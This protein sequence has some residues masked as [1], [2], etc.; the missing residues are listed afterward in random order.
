MDNVVRTERL[1]WSELP[2]RLRLAL[3][4]AVLG[5]GCTVLG[6]IL[7]LVQP[8]PAPG[9]S[10]LPLLIA[11]AVLPA[12]LAVG[13]IVAGRP[14]FAAGVL[15][16]FALLAP[17]RAVADL[18]LAWDALLA[19]RPE[20]LVPTSL[21]PMS[22]AAGL[23]ILL[24]GHV[25][26][27]LA[28]LLAVGAGAQPG[29]AYAEELEVPAGTS[30]RGG[31]R[32]LIGWA[33]VCGTVA[34]GGLL[35][36]AFYSHD[37]FQLTPEVVVSPSLVLAGGL[38][39]IAAVVLGCVVFTASAVPPALARGGL[40]GLF[41]GV[42]A[43]TMPAIVAG[44]AVPRLDPAP[45]PYIALGA[46]GLLVLIVYLRSEGRVREADHSRTELLLEANRLHL[47]AGALGIVAG[48]AALAGGLGTQLVVEAGLEQPESFANRQLVPAG[49][50]VGLLGAALLVGRWSA[51]V[52]P[53][54]T[55]SLAAVLVVGAG[56]LDA[57]LTG[58]GISP[59]VHVG[60]GVWAT[61][62]AMALAVVA[63][64]CAGVA[65]SAERD[66]VDLTEGRLN[67]P[68]VVP[69]G[70][71]GVLAIGAFALPAVRAP[72]FA[73][74][75]I[76]SDFRLGSWGLLLGLG[77]VI[78][79]CVLAPLSRAERGASLLLGAAAVVGVHLLEFPLTSGR[80]AGATPGPGTWLSAACLVALLIAATAALVGGSRRR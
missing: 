73:A 42:A 3:L 61:G 69:A 23:W 31:R 48:L 8:A 64:I 25:L 78:A 18:Q 52:R 54:F 28:G 44:L 6:L 35:L 1:G 27:A 19:S 77:V 37:A 60:F 67:Q 53:A 34:T 36:P 43:V 71:A 32:Y 4:L 63:A 17:G 41:A 9:Y 22:P 20:L 72:D 56:T 45:G 46:T 76:W 12:V 26:V 70:A 57:A 10:A 11:L 62:V 21:A 66:E 59:D 7:G 55:V 75:G 29:S 16:G 58:A 74:P 79:V 80:A 50:I 40:V 30:D 33:L 15:M 38:L 24:A 14:V 2:N 49:V 13:A 39:T 5:A 51:A 68:V 47:L 65:G